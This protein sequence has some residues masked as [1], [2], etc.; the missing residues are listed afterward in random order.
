MKIK[1]GNKPVI[2]TASLLVPV[3]EGAWVEFSAGSWQVKI[4]IVFV[5]DKD[6][7]TQ[8][9]NLQGKDD[10]AVLTIKNWNNSLPMA[11][12]EPCQLGVFDDKKVVFLFSGYAVGSLKKLDLV[13]MWGDEHGN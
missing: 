12:E 5:E 10:Y 13:F 4:N 2:Q 8:G 9:F 1:I 6:D 7:P 3:T 11:I